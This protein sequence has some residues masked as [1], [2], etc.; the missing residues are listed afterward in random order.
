MKNWRLNY[1]IHSPAIPCLDLKEMKSLSR[2]NICTLKF[3]ALLFII[4]KIWKQSKCPSTDEW[5]KEIKYIPYI[6]EYYWNEILMEY[7][8]WEVEY[9]SDIKE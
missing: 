6:M 9:Y 5:K 2:R 7:I 1:C 3:T 4:A 8:Q